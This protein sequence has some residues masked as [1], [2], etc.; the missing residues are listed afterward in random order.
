MRNATTALLLALAVAV[1]A[2]AETTIAFHVTLTDG[3]TALEA[4]PNFAELKMSD[5]QLQRAANSRVLLLDRTSGTKWTWL[6]LSWL[7]T[8]PDAE[9]RLNESG[10]AAVGKN[11]DVGVTPLDEN[12][13]RVRCLRERCEVTIAR[14]DEK[15]TATL[16]NGQSQNAAFGSDVR[17]VF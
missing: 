14:G 7:E 8:H 1:T 13:F 10:V 4:N 17:V 16:T 2:S 12:T 5:E 11:A 9:N 6:I 15:Q 3:R